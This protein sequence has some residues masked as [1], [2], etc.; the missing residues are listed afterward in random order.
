MNDC[1]IG[2][3]KIYDGCYGTREQ[4]RPNLVQRNFFFLLSITRIMC[5]LWDLRLTLFDIPKDVGSFGNNFSF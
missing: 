1:F 4:I 2:Y 3:V 5:F